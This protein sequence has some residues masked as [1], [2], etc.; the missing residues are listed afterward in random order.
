[1]KS[2][3]RHAEFIQILTGVFLVVFSIRLALVL[4]VAPE[5]PF[6]DEWDAVIDGMARPML[7]GKFSFQY[8]LVLHNEHPLLWTRA[9]SYLLLR[10]SDL[11]FDNVP[12][13][14]VSQFIYAGVAATLI[15][16]AAKNLTAMDGGNA[17]NARS[18]F[19]LTAV[20]NDRW[21]FVAGAA[22]AAA[23]PYGWENIGVGF[24]SCYYFLIGFS[25]GTIILASVVR[26]SVLTAILLGIVAAAS[27][28]SMATGLFAA[29]AAMLALVLRIR[30][31]ALT[32][33]AAT[34]PAAVLLVALASATFLIAGAG[35]VTLEWRF[36]QSAE[37]AILA[38]LSLPT[39]ILLL[40]VFR[41]RGTNAD[42]AFVCISVW[43]C[44][45]I[46]A[47]LL[48]RPA[49]RLWYPISRYFDI[50]ALTAF[51]NIGCLFRIAIADPTQR[52]RAWLSR[53]AVIAAAI[54]M[55]ALSPFAWHWMQV[56]ADNQR[57][58]TDMLVRYIHD[59]DARAIEE[60][61]AVEL[62][63]PDRARLRSLVD[64]PDVRLILG[65]AVGTRPAPSPFV[66]N[67]R[68][69]NA[70]L[71]RNG[72]WLL[73]L[74]LAIGSLILARARWRPAKPD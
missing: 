58:Q 28:A 50:L 49:F 36:I 53:A 63:Y 62:P 52:R 38:V 18:N 3:A 27:G 45:Q 67:V 60:A 42:I 71:A 54:S 44:M 16:L 41:G 22:I 35:R 1:M 32:L 47:I 5:I 68:N 23:L 73:P 59:G 61:P 56:R 31:G 14:E 6:Y 69:V 19:R 46:G 9:V 20:D 70:V 33:R 26:Y 37:L 64:A 55:L 24:G 10:A 39:W 11:Q 4:M 29:V 21:W 57:G 8:F 74:A 72:S 12:V 7:A 65:D 13:C 66:E 34:I 30:I 15:A 48:G 25:A 40:R 43:G 2:L 51:A 17:G